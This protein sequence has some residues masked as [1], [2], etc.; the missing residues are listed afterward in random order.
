MCVLSGMERITSGWGSRF[1]GLVPHDRLDFEDGGVHYEFPVPSFAAAPDVPTFASYCC[2]V[3][4]I[5]C[6]TAVKTVV[7]E[8][9]AAIT[10]G[11]WVHFE[12]IPPGVQ[13]V[14]ATAQVQPVAGARFLVEGYIHAD[15]GD[16]IARIMANCLG[17]TV[18]AADWADPM[19]D[20]SAP[21]AHATDMAPLGL[22][23]AGASG[24][25]DRQPGFVTGPATD[26]AGFQI[27]GQGQSHQRGLRAKTVTSMMVTT[28][29]RRGRGTESRHSG[30][31]RALLAQMVTISNCRATKLRGVL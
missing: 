29:D 7:G 14:S 21:P 17:A 25:T 9:V 20:R 6:T 3:A 26:A 18:A 22:T 11:L 12:A 1:F 19:T 13:R 5:A 28:D 23:T 30:I 10:Q 2:A 8:S 31:V 4:D 24:Y 15:G 27:A 16:T